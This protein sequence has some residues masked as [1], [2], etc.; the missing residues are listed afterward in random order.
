MYGQFFGEFLLQRRVVTRAQLDEGL[1]LQEERNKPL[2]VMAMDFGMLSAADVVTILE[3]QQTSEEPFGRIAVRRG[4]LTENALQ[5][6]L[7]QQ[8]EEHL[9]LGQGL[10][11]RG[12]LT[13]SDVEELL[14]EFQRQ[15]VEDGRTLQRLLRERKQGDLLA[16]MALPIQRCLSRVLSGAVKIEDVLTE[17]KGPA[18]AKR[19]AVLLSRERDGVWECTVHLP[20]PAI[21]PFVYC[22]LQRETWSERFIDEAL[23]RFGRMLAYAV[24]AELNRAGFPVATQEVLVRGPGIPEPESTIL[25][26][27]SGIGP[28]FVGLSTPVQS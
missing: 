17:W 4:L 24:A 5:R 14:K 3:E 9:F 12:F 21:L 6:L 1:R 19:I 27:N 22:L 13:H 2:G 15:S 11:E 25:R 8:A 28:L 20:R 16:R 10:V 18:L 26:L 7:A 23:A